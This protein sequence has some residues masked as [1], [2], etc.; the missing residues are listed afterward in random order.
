MYVP[1][2]LPFTGVSARISRPSGRRTGSSGKANEGPSRFFSS[3]SMVGRRSSGNSNAV[4]MHNLPSAGSS[5]SVGPGAS[6]VPRVPGGLLVE[7]TTVMEGGA[8]HARAAERI[9][10]SIPHQRPVAENPHFANRLRL[11]GYREWPPSVKLP[12]DYC[13]SLQLLQ[14]AYQPVSSSWRDGSRSR[15]TVVSA[16]R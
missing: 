5:P 9:L 1:L 4:P 7:G 10:P 13:R 14:H 15:R 16:M 3:L 8:V 11:R 6:V 12:R 2:P